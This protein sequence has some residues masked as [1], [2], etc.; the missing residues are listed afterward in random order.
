MTDRQTLTDE[1]IKTQLN[2]GQTATLEADPDSTDSD[3]TDG[4]S[5]DTTDGDSGTTDAD[6][7]DS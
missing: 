1:E 7:T 2:Q 5:S 4:D 3:G 6:G